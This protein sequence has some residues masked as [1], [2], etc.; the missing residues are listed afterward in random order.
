MARR[1]FVTP[2]DVDIAQRLRDSYTV[3]VSVHGFQWLQLN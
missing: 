3:S 1:V 2:E